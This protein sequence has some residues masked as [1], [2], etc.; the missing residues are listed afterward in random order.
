MYWK[1]ERSIVVK[2]SVSLLCFFRFPS[3]NSSCFGPTRV[4]VFY[5]L[6]IYYQFVSLRREVVINKNQIHNVTAYC[7]N[8]SDYKRFIK[9][10]GGAA[11]WQ[12]MEATNK[13]FFFVYWQPRALSAQLWIMGLFQF[14]L[15]YYCIWR[16]KN[17][18]ILFHKFRLFSNLMGK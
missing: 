13:S 9:S 11:I 12:T 6:M 17:T 7:L 8:A 5:P 16:N 18:F 10:L 15:K 3:W 1:C 2:F 14:K 4:Y